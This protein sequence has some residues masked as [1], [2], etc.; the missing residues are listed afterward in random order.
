M[1][2]IIIPA[3]NGKADFPPLPKM[4]NEREFW[5]QFSELGAST[6]RIEE[7]QK[8]MAEDVARLL[9]AE[10]ALLAQ[11][12]GDLDW[13]RGIEARLQAVES[14][15]IAAWSLRKMAQAVAL[16]GGAAVIFGAIFEA[17]RWVAA[18]WK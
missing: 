6:A 18:H 3:G 2:P 9:H 13:R 17:V 1:T 16:I 8:A 15:G 14:A 12:Q 4:A 5:Q 10:G 11:R 7:R